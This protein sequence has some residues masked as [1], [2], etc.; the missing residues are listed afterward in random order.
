MRLSCCAGVSQLKEK[1]TEFNQPKRLRRL[2]SLFISPRGK[3]VAVATGNQITVL[4]KED[5]Y[6]EPCGSFTGKIFLM[7]IN[8][9]SV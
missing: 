9:Y 8:L 5:D 3:H 6:Q 7:S 1:W 2:V 4:S